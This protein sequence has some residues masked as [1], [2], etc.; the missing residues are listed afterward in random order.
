ML[1]SDRILRD[2][3]STRVVFR[4]FGSP[5]SAPGKTLGGADDVAKAIEKLRGDAERAGYAAGYAAGHLEGIEDGA[6]S[7]RAQAER[8]RSLVDQASHDVQAA[9][10]Q[11]EPE[12]VELALTVA[13]RVIESEL[14]GHPEL[15]NDVVRAALLSTGSV[16]II[17][18]RI[19]PD[20]YT[21]L[22]SSWSTIIGSGASVDLVSDPKVQR[23]GCVVDTASGFVDAQPEIR[24]D[25][26]RRQ[27]VTRSGGAA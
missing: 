12:V 4:P 16:K 19:H 24:L 6:R 20:D 22:N 15:V 23:G 27:I 7:L 25:E 1:T 21:A 17:R 5:A 26:L 2:A 8:L 11:L 18:V 3:A 13:G 10:V 9:L 14:V